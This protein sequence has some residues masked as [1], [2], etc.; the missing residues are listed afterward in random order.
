M[1]KLTRMLAS[2]LLIIAGYRSRYR[3]SHSGRSR[4]IATTPTSMVTRCHDRRDA[5]AD[6]E[7]RRGRSL[8]RAVNQFANVKRYPPRTTAASRAE[9]DTLY[10][11]PGRRQGAAGLQHPDMGERSTS[12]DDRPMDD[13]FASPA[14]APATQG[15]RLPA[16]RPGWK[17]RCRG[18]DAYP[19]ATRYM[20]I[21][22][23]TYANGT[24]TITRR[25]MHC[26]LN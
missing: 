23:R 19:V 10:R 14:P 20:V 5:R 17:A 24:R 25:R 15:A 4:R 1:G 21:L 26:R 11:W 7:C 6:V 12:S 16:H 3:P 8:A 9:R 2:S 18:H 22:G 13:I